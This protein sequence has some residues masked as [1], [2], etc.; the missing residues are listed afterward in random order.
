LPE[1]CEENGSGSPATVAHLSGKAALDVI[2]VLS[3][4]T[5]EAITQT[6]DEK[7]GS[8]QS[9][10]QAGEEDRQVPALQRAGVY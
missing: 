4:S 6:G 2:R 9:R 1:A 7:E 8:H 3:T 10:A 5:R